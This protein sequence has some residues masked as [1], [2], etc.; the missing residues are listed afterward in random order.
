MAFSYLS[1]IYSDLSEDVY[2]EG[3][4]LADNKSVELLRSYNNGCRAM[5]RSGGKYPVT[6]GFARIGS[7]AYSCTCVAYSYDCI[8]KHIVSVAITYDQSRWVL[9]TPWFLPD[10]S[11]FLANSC[12]F[13]TERLY[14]RG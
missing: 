7:S 14:L 5:V 4:K 9:F 10:K 1:I 3:K 11:S 2:L 8:C 6:I 13:T 12:I